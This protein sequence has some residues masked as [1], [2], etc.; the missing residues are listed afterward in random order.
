MNIIPSYLFIFIKITLLHIYLL[1]LPGTELKI[2][3]LKDPLIVT[4]QVLFCKIHKISKPHIHLFYLLQLTQFQ[5]SNPFFFKSVTGLKC[6][7]PY[8]KESKIHWPNP[9]PSRIKTKICLDF[10]EVRF[11]FKTLSRKINIYMYNTAYENKC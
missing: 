3:M 5:S 6:Q 8:Q 7:S 11:N 10:V 4:L 2:C 1:L 9:V